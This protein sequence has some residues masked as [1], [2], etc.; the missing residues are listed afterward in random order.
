MAGET[1][2][3]YDFGQHTFF[4]MTG[5]STVRSPFPTPDEVI[6]LAK[7]RLLDK[8]LPHVSCDYREGTLYLRGR[9]PSFY[10]KQMAQETVR[11]LDGVEIVI[12]EIEVGS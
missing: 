7:T 6:C 10:E 5:R 9:L 3:V 2:S 11:N 4:S 12:N 1:T 8:Q